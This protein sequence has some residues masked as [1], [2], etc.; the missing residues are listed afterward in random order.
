MGRSGQAGVVLIHGSNAHLEWVASRH[1]RRPISSAA[2]DLSVTA[3]AAGE[4]YTGKNFADEA[5]CQLH[6]LA[7][8][9]VVATASADLWHWKPALRSGARRHLM[10]FTAR[11]RKNPWRGVG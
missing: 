9:M 1:C 5:V 2:I 7:T 3:T 10:D 8:P 11:R 6:S 4:R